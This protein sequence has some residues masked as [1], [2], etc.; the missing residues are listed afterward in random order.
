MTMGRLFPVNVV[1][2]KIISFWR[3]SPMVFPW[4]GTFM[5]EGRVPK[6]AFRIGPALRIQVGDGRA[7]RAVLLGFF[8]KEKPWRRSK[9]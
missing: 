3:F 7:S 5:L 2:I 6:A 1:E 9:I 8:R 4:K